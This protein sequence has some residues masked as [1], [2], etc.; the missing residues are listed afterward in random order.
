MIEDRNDWS[1]R[2]LVRTAGCYRVIEIQAGN[3]TITATDLL[4]DD[5]RT[6]GAAITQGAH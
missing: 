4:P 2:R 5:L 6:A 1:I 3:H